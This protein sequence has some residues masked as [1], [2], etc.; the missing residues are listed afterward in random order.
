[1]GSSGTVEVHN[2][3]GSQVTSSTAYEI[4]R[5]D[6][7]QKKVAINQ[8]LND[9]YPWFYKRVD[10]ETTLDG[11]GSS[12]NEYEVPADF[13][14]FPDQI[15]EKAT[16]GTKITYT[17]IVNYTATEVSGTRYF[18]ADITDG[19]DI[20]LIG[21]THLSQF[22]NDASTTEL[23]DGQASVVALLAAS[24]FYRMLSGVVDAS[25][26]ERFDSL[27]NRYDNLYEEKKVRASMPFI[28]PRKINN[29]WVDE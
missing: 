28:M 13:T 15:F 7:D 20:L 26:S 8:A 25:N 14:E 21:K 12:D 17:E 1:M 18:Y 2:A 22:T 6:R 24:I 5:F 3:F 10:D 19:N 16:S 9:S 29:E 27:S 23:T 11:K 4:H